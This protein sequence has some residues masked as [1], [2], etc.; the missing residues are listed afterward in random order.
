MDVNEK[1]KLLCKFKK[2]N[3]GRGGGLG[4]GGV[5]SGGWVVGGGVSVDGNG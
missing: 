2:K 4:Q 1:V 5:G 3:G